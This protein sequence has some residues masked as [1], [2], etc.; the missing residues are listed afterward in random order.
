MKRLVLFCCTSVVLILQTSTLLAQS[1]GLAVNTDN[2]TA[3]PLAILDVKSTTQGLL[4][5]RMTTAQRQTIGNPSIPTGLIVYDTDTQTFWYNVGGAAPNTGWIQLTTVGN[6]WFVNG[7][8]GLVDDNQFLGTTDMVPLNIKVGNFPSGRIDIN[9]ANTTW[10]FQAGKSFSNSATHTEFSTAIGYGA[11][12]N[13]SSSNIGLNTGI[14][15]L[16]LYNNIGGYSNTSVGSRALYHNINGYDNTAIGDQALFTASDDHCFFNT[17]IG[18]HALYS[19][20][21]LGNS[22]TAYLVVKNPWFYRG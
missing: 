9:S 16:A 20:D 13:N 6:A 8:A 21:K 15:A 17:A 3:H 4:I 1:S 19:T 7:N 22:N 10:G 12:A 2:S 11:L 14:G 18:S 5:P